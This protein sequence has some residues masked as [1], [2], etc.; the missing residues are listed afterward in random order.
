[1]PSPVTVWFN[2]NL[3]ST[4]Q[5]LEM[6]RQEARPDEFRFLATHSHPDSPTFRFADLSQLEPS[7][8]SDEDYLAWCRDTIQRF[9]VQVF[10]P[11][12][13]L[14]RIARDR[15]TFETSG[16]RLLTAADAV[17][18]EL[19][20]SK[21]KTYR[22][23]CD[24]GIALP[25]HRR[26]NTLAE[27]D[28]AYSELREHHATV[29]FKPSESMFGLG[30]RILT[31]EPGALKRLLNGDPLSIGLDEA[32]RCFGEQA[33]FRDVLVM[34]YLP[35]VERSVDCLAHGGELVRCVIRRKPEFAEGA[36]QIENH[37][38][39]ERAVRHIVDR[40]ELTG[41]FNIQFK[42]AGQVPYLLEINPRMSG[43]MPMACLSGVNLPL[44]GLR[45]L[46]GTATAADVPAVQFGR[47]VK[48]MSRA[49]LIAE[50]SS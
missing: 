50:P 27:F 34:Q 2:K 3:S 49:V 7:G 23:L 37:P 47:R 40:L 43:G 48:D 30:F 21:F 33:R 22:R 10:V 8:L 1:M 24:A 15:A 35:G 44:W 39:I 9:D 36:Q 5:V 6:I 12:K 31:E 45:L 28:T 29:C 17:T 19:L 46:L 14:A 25:D 4:G 13:L 11:G 41:L 32:R 42:D 18:L 38:E 26:V 16:V 20:D